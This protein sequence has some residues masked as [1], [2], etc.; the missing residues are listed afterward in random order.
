MGL[1]IP[2][3]I[4]KHLFPAKR[5]RVLSRNLVFLLKRG[6]MTDRCATFQWISMRWRFSVSHG[7]NEKKLFSE[8]RKGIKLPWAPKTY[9]FR[10]FMVNN[11]VFRWPKPLYGFGA[12]WYSNLLVDRCRLC[13]LKHGEHEGESKNCDRMSLKNSSTSQQNNLH[14]P[15]LA[16]P[17]KIDGWKM[18]FLLK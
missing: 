11:L 12:S 18:Y 15:K 9:I 2:F 10:G 16:C 6:R 17:L 3:Y 4:L 5:H 13:S 1:Y 14:S 7:L 8:H